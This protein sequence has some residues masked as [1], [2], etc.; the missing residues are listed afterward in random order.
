M[1]ISKSVSSV[2]WSDSIELDF[3]AI[4]Y[5]VFFLN[6]VINLDSLVKG[7]H[8]CSEKKIVNGITYIL[9]KNANVKADPECLNDCIYYKEGYRGYGYSPYY[10]FKKGKFNPYCIECQGTYIHLSMSNIKFYWDYCQ[11]KNGKTAQKAC[12]SRANQ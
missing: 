8:H 12:R 4:S 3:K 2:L 6:I 1:K 11:Y 7:A 5:L 10:C 9:D